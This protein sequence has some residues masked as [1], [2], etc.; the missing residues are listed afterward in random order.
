M[1][2]FRSLLLLTVLAGLLVACGDP[3]AP[4]FPQPDRD[5][6][7]DTGDGEQTGF[8]VQFLEAASVLA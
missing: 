5:E 7:S 4:R 8:Q 6:K 3:M 1:K 2:T